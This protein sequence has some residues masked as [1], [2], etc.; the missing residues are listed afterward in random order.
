M[1]HHLEEV[2]ALKMFLKSLVP[3]RAPNKPIGVSEAETKTKDLIDDLLKFYD[4]KLKKSDHREGEGGILL[5]YHV[6]VGGKKFVLK[7]WV[8]FETRFMNLSLWSGDGQD[9]LE[10]L[11]LTEID[12]KFRLR[13][14]AKARAASWFKKE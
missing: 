11:A 4:G 13:A 9:L 5:R 1:M 6:V 3:E 14:S 8:V 2:S 7:A 12:K 10:V